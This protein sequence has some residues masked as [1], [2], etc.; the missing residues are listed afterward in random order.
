M[1]QP[2]FP[3]TNSQGHCAGQEGITMRQYYK[4]M[5]LSGLTGTNKMAEYPS[6]YARIVGEIAD[7]MLKED[8]GK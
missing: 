3:R 7:A 4:G 6:D 5:A 8:E 1:N 2:A